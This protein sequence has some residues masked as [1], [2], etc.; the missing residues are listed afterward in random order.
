MKMLDNISASQWLAQVNP[1]AIEK[2]NTPVTKIGRE[3]AD[4][5]VTFSD[6]LNRLQAPVESSIADAQQAQLSLL[7]GEAQSV[8]SVVLAAEKADIALQMT[9]T[10]RNKVIDAYN[11]IMRMQL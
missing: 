5:S 10:I 9:M 2:L 1:Q 8:H 4:S 3:D 6:V 11:E 7:T